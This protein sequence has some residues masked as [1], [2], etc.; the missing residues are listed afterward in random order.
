MYFNRRRLTYRQKTFKEKYDRDF[1]DVRSETLEWLSHQEL[2]VLP[3][4]SGD[5]DHGGYESI[6][7]APRN[8]SFFV[9]GLADLQ[10][11]IPLNEIR[12]GYKPRAVIY[13]APTFRHTHFDGKQAVVHNRL[14]DVHE[15]FSFNLYPGPSAKKG[16]YGILLSIGEKEGWV[17]AHAA[18]AHI[19]TPYDNEVVIMHE[20]ASGGGNLR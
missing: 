14:D 8:A 17:T 4:I 18:T 6:L 15:V 3:F 20:G 16:V 2:V 5:K 9:G 10:G 11:F 1:K 19:T 7:I 12:E 13:L